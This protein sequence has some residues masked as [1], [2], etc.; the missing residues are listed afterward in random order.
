MS[1]DACWFGSSWYDFD[2]SRPHAAPA[3]SPNSEPRLGNEFQGNCASHSE[4]IGHR[5]P[6]FEY[7][8]VPI[9]PFLAASSLPMECGA[10][11]GVPGY[12]APGAR[13]PPFASPRPGAL[14]NAWHR[15]VKPTFAIFMS[16]PGHVGLRPTVPHYLLRCGTREERRCEAP[17][18]LRVRRIWAIFLKEIYYLFLEIDLSVCSLN[19]F[20]GRFLLVSI[21]TSSAEFTIKFV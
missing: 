3:L 13:A 16:G 9:P 11:K 21:S 4:A 8:P 7:V 2:P 20:S 14:C 15:A 19:T 18:S 12:P 6:L 5:P 1:R 10:R 17:V